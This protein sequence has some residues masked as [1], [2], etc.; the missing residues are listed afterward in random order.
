[1][2]NDNDDYRQKID[3]GSGQAL[4]AVA[5]LAVSWVLRF[6]PLTCEFIERHHSGGR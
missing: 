2:T 1:M 4:A 5:L 6:S 3:N